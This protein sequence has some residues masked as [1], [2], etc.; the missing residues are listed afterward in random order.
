MP[1]PLVDEYVNRYLAEYARTRKAS[2]YSTQQARL[3]RFA[4]DFAGRRLDVS[5]AEAREW[6]NRVPAGIVPAVIALYNFAIDEDDL[7]LERNPFRK[8]AR[9]SNGRANE[10]PPT[11]EQFKRLGDAALLAHGE[12]GPTMRALIRFAAFSL[13]RPGELYAL[14][15][16]DLEGNRIH[17]R[18]RVYRGH[19]DTPKTGPKIIALTPPAREALA[20]LPRG[21]Y[22]FPSKTGKRLSQP[23]LSLYWRTVLDHADLEFDFY[24]ATKHYGVHYFWT[25]LGLSNRAIAAQAGWAL[26]TVDAM[27]AVYG[28]GEIG[29]LNEVD[30]AFGKVGA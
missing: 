20:D 5:R 29:A 22:V 1:L 30:T 15:W 19:V 12:Y 9:R 2:S 11:A 4:A 7:P 18:R 13:M 26:S 16:G 23:L 28:H 6:A 17:C 14:E 3:H 27:L 8:L 10:A 24:H 21:R 25:E